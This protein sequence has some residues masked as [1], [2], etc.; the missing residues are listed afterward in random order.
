MPYVVMEINIFFPVENSTIF[1]IETHI[2]IQPHS[3]IEFL[4]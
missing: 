4:P 1:F 3:L 2:E